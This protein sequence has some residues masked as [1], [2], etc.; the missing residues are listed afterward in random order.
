MVKFLTPIYVYFYC[1]EIEDKNLSLNP[2]PSPC[3]QSSRNNSVDFHSQPWLSSLY[4][5]IELC[6]PN[7]NLSSQKMH[8]ICNKAARKS[9]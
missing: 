8:Q 9:I 3:R 4:T 1:F 2:T 7:T 5:T 6:E